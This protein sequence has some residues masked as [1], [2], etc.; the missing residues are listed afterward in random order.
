MNYFLEAT[1]VQNIEVYIEDGLS[2]TL[3]IY[4]KIVFEFLSELKTSEIL[5]YLDQIQVTQIQIE[6]LTSNNFYRQFLL[7]N[8]F[9]E[10]QP[11]PTN[12]NQSVMLG[13]DGQDFI[14]DINYLIE[15]GSSITIAQLLLK[16]FVDNQGTQLVYQSFVKYDKQ[17][18]KQQVEELDQIQLNLQNI[19]VLHNNS[20]EIKLNNQQ[21]IAANPFE[22]LDILFIIMTKQEALYLISNFNFQIKLPYYLIQYNT[23]YDTIFHAK[24]DQF[25]NNILQK[26]NISLQVNAQYIQDNIQLQNIQ[27]SGDQLILLASILSCQ[28]QEKC[29]IFD[30]VNMKISTYNFNSILVGQINKSGKLLS[31]IIEI[32]LQDKNLQQSLFSTASVQLLLDICISNYPLISISSILMLRT[33]QDG[34]VFVNE[35]LQYVA[36]LSILKSVP[37]EILYFIFEFSQS[38]PWIY[39]NINFQGQ[40]IKLTKGYL[41]QLATNIKQCHNV[42][43]IL[44]TDQVPRLYN[45]LLPSIIVDSVQNFIRNF[46]FNIESIADCLVSNIFPQLQGSDQKLINFYPS[47]SQFIVLQS[48]LNHLSAMMIDFTI[49]LSE[50]QRILSILL[51]I[52]NKYNLIFQDYDQ[53]MLK[54]YNTE[55]QFTNLFIY[56][57]V[58]VIRQYFDVDS[59]HLQSLKAERSQLEQAA[60]DLNISFKKYSP[61]LQQKIKLIFD[62]IQNN[63]QIYIHTDKEFNDLTSTL[64]KLQF[65]AIKLPD[66]IREQ[67]FN[68][69]IQPAIRKKDFLYKKRQ[70]LDQEI[71]LSQQE[72]S[73]L[74]QEEQQIFLTLTKFYEKKYHYDQIHLELQEQQASCDYLKSLFQVNLFNLYGIS[75]K[76]WLMKTL[77]KLCKNSTFTPI[78]DQAQFKNIVIC[79]IPTEKIR[80]ELNYK[81]NQIT[82]KTAKQFGQQLKYSFQFDKNFLVQNIICERLIQGQNINEIILF[83]Q[84]LYNFKT[85]QQ[86]A[87]FVLQ[88]FMLPFFFYVFPRF[89]ILDYIHSNCIDKQTYQTLTDKFSRYFQY[90]KR[91]ILI[92]DDK[93][94]IKQ[95]NKIQVPEILE[96]KTQQTNRSFVNIQIL[97]VL[98]TMSQLCT[99]R[100]YFYTEQEF[101]IIWWLLFSFQQNGGILFIKMS[102]IFRSIIE[103]YLEQ[104]PEYK[105]AGIQVLIYN[106][107]YLVNI[108]NSSDVPSQSPFYFIFQSEIINRDY[109]ILQQKLKSLG[110]IQLQEQLPDNKLLRLLFQNIPNA[111]QKHVCQLQSKGNRIR[112]IQSLRSVKQHFSKCEILK[113]QLMNICNTLEPNLITF[114]TFSILNYLAIQLQKLWTQV[115]TQM[116]KK[117]QQALSLAAYIT[118]DDI[119]KNYTGN[120]FSQADLQQFNLII[121]V[122]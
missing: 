39:D 122:K 11:L 6:Q 75:N 45:N 82:P 14:L 70:E 16:S 102:L 80:V 87:D 38:L 54:L 109:E 90:K 59:Q 99:M 71:Q 83:I 13:Q 100:Q 88:N 19:Q 115:S 63:K 28:E 60:Q 21:L 74:S 113:Q 121:N 36:Q 116:D 65:Q 120:I 12:Y 118:I 69:N 110:I 93:Q 107:V 57:L 108:I 29:T 47:Y 84:G 52:I 114:D 51:F 32:F 10:Q 42:D 79:E 95:I 27:K 46:N 30:K 78:Y 2:S 25:I 97:N 73:Q 23:V 49:K 76:P 26:Q 105:I 58:Q 111:I 22:V 85:L 37:L 68:S 15:N 104:Q 35:L 98:Q 55:R 50:R 89:I 31:K 5:K 64:S 96:N 112:I 20:L 24:L 72:I 77:Q 67:F 101:D 117:Q 41:V 66:N 3:K 44:L 17:Q 62:Q 1:K 94:A 91:L 4:N 81:L 119:L 7:H 92:Q 18:L 33:Y 61:L 8:F 103:Q 106:Y 43:I 34:P 56:R 53:V 48:T 86:T 9:G 40:D